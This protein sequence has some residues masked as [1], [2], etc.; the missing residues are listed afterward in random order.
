M[1]GSDT[2][3]PATEI[4]ENITAIMSGEKEV[5][6]SRPARLSALTEDEMMVQNVIEIG[7]VMDSAKIWED[8]TN[9]E[10]QYPARGETE[11]SFFEARE[12]SVGLL[13]G[14]RLIMHELADIPKTDDGE[15]ADFGEDIE[16][17]Y[18]I[19]DKNGHRD[20]LT[21]EETEAKKVF[22]EKHNFGK[23]QKKQ[24]EEPEKE[25]DYER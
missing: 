7:A 16:M 4:A 5:Y 15:A 6:D 21:H 19:E 13:D 2:T 3:K 8:Y 22:L 17:L 23:E 25:Q 12:Y 11:T 14:Y 10:E 9:I 24:Q 1:T 20:A 18:F